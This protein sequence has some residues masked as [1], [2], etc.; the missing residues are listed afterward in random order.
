MSDWKEL[1]TDQA[2]SY[3]TPGSQYHV[4]KITVSERSGRYRL[5]VSEH[6]GSNQ[7]HRQDHHSDDRQYRAD[8]LDDLMR[9][10]IAAERDLASPERV[11]TAIRNAIY[12]AE[13]VTTAV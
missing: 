12:E 5:Q 9:I 6:A 11:A 2:G 10:A 7:G 13:D 3:G 8:D 1:T 4:H